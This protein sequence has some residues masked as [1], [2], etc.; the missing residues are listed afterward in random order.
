MTAVAAVMAGNAMTVM[1]VPPFALIR[2]D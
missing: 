2:S 1:A